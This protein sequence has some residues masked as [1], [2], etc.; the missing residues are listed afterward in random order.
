MAASTLIDAQ[1][2]IDP[3]EDTKEL[4][5]TLTEFELTSGVISAEDEAEESAVADRIQ[6]RLERFGKIAPEAKKISRAL[7]FGTQHEAID[8]TAKK[9]RLE[10]FGVATVSTEAAQEKKRQ[11]GERFHT[12]TPTSVVDEETKQ[13]RIDRFGVVTPPTSALTKKNTNGKPTSTTPVLTEEIKK[14]TERFGDISQVAKTIAV[15]EQKAKR[16]ERFK[17]ITSV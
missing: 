5:E 14:R 13:K 15:D 9:R 8:E 6:Q 3:P 7:R 11:R 4:A 1:P 2:T 16:A 17:P 12:D 10:R